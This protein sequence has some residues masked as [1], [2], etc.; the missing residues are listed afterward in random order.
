MALTNLPNA[1][2]VLRIL[3]VPVFAF[4]LVYRF[5]HFALYVYVVAGVS[6]AVDGYL[7]R[8]LNLQSELGRLLDPLADK[9]LVLTS[10]IIFAF[11]EWIPAWLTITVL[12]RDI[13]VLAGW[14]LLFLLY[15]RKTVQPTL[16]G[17]TANAL[18]MFIVGYVLLGK[19][20]PFLELPGYFVLFVLTAALTAL[21]G[22]HYMIRGLAITHA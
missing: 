14:F 10:L 18:Q 20:L 8:R 21:S 15:G 3:L 9:T 11:L 6:D 13:F 5:Y 7:A 17:K 16:V 12:S 4:L 22:L 1:I 2:T 19:V